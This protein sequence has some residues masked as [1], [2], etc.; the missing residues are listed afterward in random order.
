MFP[1]LKELDNEVVND[2]V[3]LAAIGTQLTSDAGIMTG[4]AAMY[5]KEV[6]QTWKQQRNPWPFLAFVSRFLRELDEESHQ[7]FTKDLV[8][9]AFDA[10][11]ERFQTE[12][13]AL[14]ISGNRRLQLALSV[15][16]TIA[17]S[18]REKRDAVLPFMH[19]QSDAIREANYISSLQLSQ[20]HLQSMRDPVTMTTHTAVHSISITYHNKAQLYKETAARKL[21]RR[22]FSG[23]IH[24]SKA[25]KELAGLR[26]AS[27]A[28][29]LRKRAK[30]ALRIQPVWRGAVTRLRLSRAKLDD[31][32]GEIF[33]K[34]SFDE[35]SGGVNFSNFSALVHSAFAAHPR[36]PQFHPSPANSARLTSA[37]KPSR[38]ESDDVDARRPSSNPAGIEAG[39]G[40]GSYS[41]PR[42]RLEEEW[43]DLAEAIRKRDKKRERARNDAIRKDFMANPLKA[44][45]DLGRQ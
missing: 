2:D 18:K 8:A 17:G 35:P 19:V 29:R 28:G 36:A 39:D 22:W 26:E 13:D 11:L 33:E 1:L 24:V 4:V 20:D 15:E 12:Y 44:K 41:K 32:D 25:R 42:S 9:F 6:L 23:C 30:A 5:Q 38:K 31:D 45:R 37:P 10:Q 21:L 40:E 34:V 43:G 27:E 14:A 3:R 16:E 7:Q